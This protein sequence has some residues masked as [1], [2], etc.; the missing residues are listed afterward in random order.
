[1]NNIIN[2]AI[3]L[4]L[5]KGWQAVGYSTVGRAIVDLAAGQAAMALDLDYNLDD[6]G[7]PVGDPITINPVGW[8]EWLTLPVR[9]FDFSVHYANGSK[10]MRVPTVLVA[11]LYDKMPVKTFKGKP[12]KEGV[13]IRD[14]NR[15]Q[16]TGQLLKNDEGSIDHVIPS[17]RG[18]LD[19]WENLVWSSK[20][21]NSEKGNQLNSEANLKLIRPPSVPKP[22][23]VSLLIRE[24]R[25]RDW[26]PFLFNPND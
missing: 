16:Y 17:S 1:M 5:N 21:I 12:S 2:K 26:K 24:V 13:R 25:H 19:S 20:K 18:G 14:G 6:D 8:D 3:V 9:P 7:A 22:I 15:C 10:T 4:K 11:R 23:P